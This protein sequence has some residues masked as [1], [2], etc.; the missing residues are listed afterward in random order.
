MPREKPHWGE[1]SSHQAPFT[2]KRNHVRVNCPDIGRPHYQFNPFYSKGK[3]EK[4]NYDFAQQQ[5]RPE[6]N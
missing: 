1:P 4:M 2:Y 6:V 3:A 5:P